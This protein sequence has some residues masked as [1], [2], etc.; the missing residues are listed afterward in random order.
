MTDLA[1]NRL[2]GN[3]D[4]VSSDSYAAVF[5]KG[6]RF[7]YIDADGDAVS[8]N[9]TGG[10]VMDFLQPPRSDIPDLRFS[11]LVAGRSTLSGRV[12]KQLAGDGMTTL[13]MPPASGLT[14]KLPPAFRSVQPASSQAIDALLA[15][16]R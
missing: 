13:S 5:G 15:A 1:G 12:T 16:D 10:G 7:N 3:G 2:D 4:G 11:R 6:V 9:I 14:V 8:L